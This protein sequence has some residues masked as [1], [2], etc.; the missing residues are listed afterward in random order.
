MKTGILAIGL[1]MTLAALGACSSA[2]GDEPSSAPTTSTSA[3]SSEAG[4]PSA[5]ASPALRVRGDGGQWTNCVPYRPSDGDFIWTGTMIKADADATLDRVSSPGSHGV[6]VVG[7]W[8][9][10]S[11]G[12]GGAFVPWD[13]ADDFLR[14]MDWAHRESA[15]G[16]ELSAGN[17]YQVVLRLRPKVEQLPAELRTLVV[18]Y[19]ADGSAGSLTNDTILQFGRHC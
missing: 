16:A 17:R 15:R 19:A 6:R 12:G 3:T 7:T 10:E 13:K 2:D 4:S 9:A 8:V 1:T 11:S 18:D 14:R 5:A